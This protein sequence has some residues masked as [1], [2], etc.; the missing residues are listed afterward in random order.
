MKDAKEVSLDLNNFLQNTMLR[1]R[2]NDGTYTFIYLAANRKREE[3]QM[4][5]RELGGAY[6]QNCITSKA[7]EEKSPRSQISH[8]ILVQLEFSMIL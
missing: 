8:V 6:D 5:W 7:K 1:R 4:R 3:L 2:T